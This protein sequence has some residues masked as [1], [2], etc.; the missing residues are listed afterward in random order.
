MKSQE[1]GGRGGKVTVVRYFGIR[2]CSNL[3]RVRRGGD[4]T[5][6]KGNE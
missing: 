6:E 3:Q 2:S 4:A 5:K 1:K